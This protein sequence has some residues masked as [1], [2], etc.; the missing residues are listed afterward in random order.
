LLGRFNA[1]LAE[2]DVD[3]CVEAI[4]ALDQARLDWGADTNVSDEADY[5]RGAQRTM[6]VRLGELATV[7]A[8]DPR[9]SLAPL[10]EALLSLRAKARDAKDFATSD[11]IR[12]RLTAAG[13]QVR[14]TP[15]GAQW[16][17]AG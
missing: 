5:A 13:V 3:E 16:E 12:D 8:R 14:D 1:A 9:E 17:L 11:E 15:A 4:L 6:V 7:G 2:R 10:V